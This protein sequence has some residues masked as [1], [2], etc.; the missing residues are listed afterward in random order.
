MGWA[1]QNT[2]LS[3]RYGVA[4]ERTIA[5]GY[6][7]PGTALTSPTTFIAVH[8]D[9]GGQEVGRAGLEP[10]ERGFRAGQLAAAL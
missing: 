10:D 5:T 3:A 2:K 6:R 1:F 7:Q 8:R 9:L 4:D